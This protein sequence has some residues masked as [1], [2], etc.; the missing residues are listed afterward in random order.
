MIVESLSLL[1]VTSH[2]FGAWPA[3]LTLGT[4]ARISDAKVSDSPLQAVARSPAGHSARITCDAP[5][6]IVRL[7]VA[8]VTPVKY[9]TLAELG[10]SVTAITSPD[11]R[12]IR[13]A[14]VQDDVAELDRRITAILDEYAETDAERPGQPLLGGIFILHQLGP[15]PLPMTH[16]RQSVAPTPTLAKGNAS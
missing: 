1:T 14:L 5:A 9:L 3:L 16:S 8:V 13:H 10:C 11:V 7:A 15:S 2:E 6:S 4:L 12:M